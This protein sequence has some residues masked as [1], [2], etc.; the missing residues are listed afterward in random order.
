MLKYYPELVRPASAPVNPDGTVPNLPPD[1]PEA[2]PPSLNDW[3]G[4][5]DVQKTAA[6]EAPAVPS[7]PPPTASLAPAAPAAARVN[8]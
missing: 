6:T 4:G 7:T 2:G 8:H 3:G 1:P 5:T